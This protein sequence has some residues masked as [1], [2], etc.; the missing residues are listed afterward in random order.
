MYT[1]II[2]NRFIVTQAS[3]QKD[4]LIYWV[5]LNDQLI[6]E[7][8]LGD[9]IN[10]N[11]VCQ[12][13][14]EIAGSTVRFDAIAETLHCTNLGS[15]K[16]NDEVNVELSLKMGDRLGG[17]EMA[18]HVIGIAT[19]TAIQS[20]EENSCLTL[21][22]PTDWMPYIL[23]KGFIALEGASL[24]V[25]NPKPNGAF[26]VHLIPETRQRTTLGTKTVGDQLN[27]ELDHKTQVIVDTVQQMLTSS[28][29]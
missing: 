6:N 13:V 9:S 25:T 2:Y 26:S 29:N 11:G 12:T 16:K 3:H 23:H 1:G 10:I 7:V 18:G 21:S 8:Q 15:L 22:C 4:S 19:I 5:T 17:H 24:T 14:A 20:D 27:V 28:I